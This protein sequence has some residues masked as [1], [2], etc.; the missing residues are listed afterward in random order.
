MYDGLT[1]FFIHLL[2]DVEAVGGVAARGAEGLLGDPAGDADL[3]EDVA[4]GLENRQGVGHHVD[5]HQADR[6]LV[7]GG[8]SCGGG[9]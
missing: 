3:V 1:E 6:A 2:Q 7:D 8:R 9:G 5:L 4:A